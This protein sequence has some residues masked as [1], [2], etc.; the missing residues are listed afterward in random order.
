ME[1]K[2][3]VQ[4][5][6]THGTCSVKTWI[7]PLKKLPI[8]APKVKLSRP[9]IGSRK[10]CRKT[11][12]SSHHHFIVLLISFQTSATRLLGSANSIAWRIH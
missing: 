11:G 1:L 12:E 6:A 2:L 4:P 8:G 3:L 5:P 10:T 9:C 7:H